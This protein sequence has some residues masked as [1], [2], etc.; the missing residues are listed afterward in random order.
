MHI[1]YDKL[2]IS[3]GSKTN[4][5]N[6]PGLFDRENKE[7]FFLKHL[8]HARIIRRRILECFERASN[9]NVCIEEK[10]RL[11]SFIVVGGGPTSVEFTAELHDF[12]IDDL[13]RMYADLIPYVN[14]SLI[15]ASPDLLGTFSKTLRDYTKRSLLKRKINVVTSQAVKSIEYQPRPDGWVGDHTE[16][17]LDDGTRLSFGTMI[18]SAG[19]KQIRLVDRLELEKGRGGRILVNNHQQV[20]HPKHQNSVWALGDCC[21]NENQPCPP[22]AQVA[23]Q[24]AKYIAKMLN[25]GTNMV[26]NTPPFEFFSLGA[27]SQLGLGRGVLDLTTMGAPNSGQKVPEQVGAWSGFTAWLSWRLAYW[28]KQM[29]VGNKILIPMHWFKTFFFGRDI[30][31]F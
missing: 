23:Q 18:W 12:L 10:T 29:S 26:E 1:P 24:Q 13:K 27:M 19:L 9:P 17:V 7:V 16:A 28:G 5:F 4:T 30:S 3:V 8:S 21:V 15:E 2:L 11:L 20:C 22:T 25:T 6:T 31:R 14:I